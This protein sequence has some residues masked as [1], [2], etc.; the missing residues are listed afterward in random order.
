MPLR[1]VT[2]PPDTCDA[3][4]SCVDRKDASGTVC[5]AGDASGC[6]PDDVC[7]G[8]TNACAPVVATA[9]TSCGDAD[10]TARKRRRH[11]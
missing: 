8:T 6:N 5:Q 4:G 10:T 3:A 2:P 7:N 9:G 1:R 11:V